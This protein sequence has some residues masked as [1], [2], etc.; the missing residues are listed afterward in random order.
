[1]SAAE[2]ALPQIRAATDPGAKGGEFYAPRFGNNGPPV[3][4]PILRPGITKA[5]ETLWKVSERETGIA[6]DVQGALAKARA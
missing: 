2:G 5:V 1:M 3:R 6:L 4:R